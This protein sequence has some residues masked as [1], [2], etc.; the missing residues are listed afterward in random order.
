MA[1]SN[2]QS[3]GR[4][5][6]RRDWERAALATIA[7]EGVAALSIPKLAASLGVTKGSFYWHF[8]SLDA[9]LAAVL[10]RWERSYTDRR[11]E[12]F[13]TE[14]SSPAERL[15]PW[16]AEAEADHEAQA[17]YLE[18]S[19]AAATRADFARTV[20]R[21]IEKRT[22]FLTRAYRELGFPPRAARRRAVIAYAGYVG[23]LHL[24]RLAPKTVGP[25][26]E[27]AATVREA[28]GLLGGI[29]ESDLE[30]EAK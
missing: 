7:E 9:L 14:I 5:L 4:R 29:T 18:I 30:G 28:M 22:E 13:E 2:Q 6:E 26:R 12:R 27:R 11:I 15:K 16:S 8:D 10:E 23:M 24:A 3:P 19:A 1:R 21:V 17:L 20:A 25:P